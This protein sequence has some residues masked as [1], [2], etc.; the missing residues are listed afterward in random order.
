MRLLLFDIDGTLVS[1]ERSA[2]RMMLRRVVEEIFAI[3]L[4]PHFE[5]QL[6]GKTDYQ[7]MTETAQMLDLPTKLVEEK[8]E[9]IQDV[10]TQHTATLSNPETMRILEGVKH[11]VEHLASRNDVALA[12]LTGN[13]ET[14][15]LLKLRPHGLD[16]H[17]PVGAFGSDHIDRTMLPPIALKRANAHY[18]TQHG[19]H[20]N[21]EA[22][23]TLIIGDTLNDIACA[24]AHGIKTLA[25]ATGTV[26]M[27]TLREAGAE[28]V[29]EN[30]ADMQAITDIA[31]NF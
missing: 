25:V 7:I 16:R 20:I 14:T 17:F 23:N 10:L 27:G 21:F 22:K 6:G 30:F 3:E 2:S 19:F 26:G 1:V 15:A 24:K 4:P 29:V 31:T 8:R 28:F 5:F 18:K 12:L 11:L 9:Q 13:L